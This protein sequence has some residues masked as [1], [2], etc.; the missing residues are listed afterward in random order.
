MATPSIGK[1][2]RHCCV[3]LCNG[4]GRLRPE[5]SFHK[6][7][8]NEIVRKLWIQA[9]RRDPGP[10]FNVKEAVVCSRHFKAEDYKWTPVRTTLRPGSVPSTFNGTKNSTLRRPI[11]K[12][13]LPEKLQKT[14][15]DG[16]AE[17][18][19]PSDDNLLNENCCPPV[20]DSSSVSSDSDRIKMLESMLRERDES[21][22]RLQQKLDI[23][24]FGVE[25]F[26]KDNS[27]IMFYTGFMTFSIFTAVFEFIKPAASSMTSY[28]YRVSANANP[29]LTGRQR[30]MLLIDEFFMFLSR[31]K[32]GLMEQD[33]AVRFNCHISTYG[34]VHKSDMDSGK[35]VNSV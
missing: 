25:R 28:Y 20:E 29:N 9:I 8:S 3:P 31:L 5:L 7:P 30:N 26:S 6:F 16:I 21:I 11:I 24:R 32:C 33:L 13:P 18:L 27:T 34:W 2:D 23:E 19:A 14:D 1:N 10:L 12:N 4:N 15:K 22:A 35:H 17:A